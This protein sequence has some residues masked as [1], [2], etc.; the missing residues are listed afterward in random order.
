MK[1]LTLRTSQSL[2]NGIQNPALKRNKVESVGYVSFNKA[3]NMFLCHLH[4]EKK[5]DGIFDMCP[6]LKE[7]KK[8]ER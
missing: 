4:V 3:R 8:D 7:F 5:E 2:R 1:R 6:H